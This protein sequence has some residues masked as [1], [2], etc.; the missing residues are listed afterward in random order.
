MKPLFRL[1]SLVLFALLLAPAMAGAV[2]VTDTR[3]LTQPAQ[4]LPAVDLGH[5]DIKHDGLR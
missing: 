5:H 4:D 3:M 1:V 2:N